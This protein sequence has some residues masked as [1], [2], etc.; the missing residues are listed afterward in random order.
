M[1]A[2]EQVKVARLLR[3]S[4]ALIGDNNYAAIY[5]AMEAI[6]ENLLRAR[7]FADGGSSLQSWFAARLDSQ[8]M[9]AHILDNLQ[10][11]TFSD[12]DVICRQGDPADAI[13]FLDTGRIDVVSHDA[14]GEPF[15]IYSYMRHTMLGEMGF[16]QQSTRSAD[17]IARGPA[18]VF[19]L[20]RDVYN[21]LKQADDPLID[22]LLQ[23]I[24]TTLSDRI[25]SAN[26]TIAELQ[27]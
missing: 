25:V 12:G 27:A 21:R 26:R 3:R 6:E 15:R 5:D 9:A 7:E 1:P 14:P 11:E 23:L 20:N 22:A 8:E 19:S 10:A 2:N 16:V 18:R 4:P 24:A 13:Y 17:L